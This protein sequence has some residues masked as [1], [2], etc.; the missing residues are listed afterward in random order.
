[1][2]TNNRRY[3]LSD[4]LIHFFRDLDLETP[5]A[6]PT[7]DHWGYGSTTEDWQL[8]AFFLLRHAVRQGRLWATW[9]VRG[10]R[11]TIYGP[12][13]AVC[14]TEMPIA[15]FIE[16]SSIRAAKGEKMGTCALVLPKRAAFLA[17]ARPVIYA[18][19]TDAWSSGTDGERSF[20]DTA[21]P[22]QEQYRY[23][24]YDPTKK[25]LDWSHE[26]EWRWPLDVEPYQEDEDGIPPSDSDDLPGL[27]LDHSTMS[28]LG[29]IVADR[30]QADKLIYDILT[31]VDRGDISESHYS[32]ILARA[33]IPDWHALRGYSQTEEAIWEN[34]IDLAQFF[35]IKK[36][37]AKAQ[38]YGLHELAAAIEDATDEPG[39]QH[40]HE[41]G[42]CWLWLKDN[43]HPLVRALIRL[44]AVTITKDG[45][46][47]IELPEIDCRRP[48]R[49][50]QE[51]IETLCV[52]LAADLA[53]AG[54][55]G[56]STPTER[57][58]TC[59]SGLSSVGFTR[60]KAAGA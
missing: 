2:S 17:G 51:M 37:D 5:D 59:F 47:L 23:I 29:V 9:S 58:A 34:A 33:D 52:K 43:R 6:P 4:R 28:G 40:F 55:F 19:S 57:R 54:S 39:P 20:A 3:D 41:E 46:Y 7:P 24:A 30:Q 56:S 13:P 16:A 10:G 32:F 11:R 31:K 14:F 44:D 35:T 21:L 15:A 27:N 36:A 49:Q 48:L 12:R 38:R 53:T 50:R 42:G 18:L 26:R 8:P 22:R 25:Q 60:T 1:M 45:R